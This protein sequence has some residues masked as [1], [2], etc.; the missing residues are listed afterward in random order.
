[1]IMMMMMMM[2]TITI[3]NKQDIASLG[4][5]KFRHLSRPEDKS[6]NLM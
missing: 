5:T 6:K 2:I 3:K 1:M 4:R